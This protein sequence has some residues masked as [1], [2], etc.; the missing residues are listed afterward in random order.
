MFVYIYFTMK[1]NIFCKFLYKITIS[2]TEKFYPKEFLKICVI[3]QLK[4]HYCLYFLYI[5]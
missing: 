5:F 3:N 1:K 2:F 4:N